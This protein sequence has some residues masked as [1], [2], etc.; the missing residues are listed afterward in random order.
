[1]SD[2][3]MPTADDYPIESCAFEIC[4]M[5][6]VITKDYE[7]LHDEYEK[8]LSFVK[9]IV[10]SK[11]TVIDTHIRWQAHKLLSEIGESE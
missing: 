11:N 5:C 3:K 4:N 9:S 1:M 2:F 8:L 10:E 7:E 6:E